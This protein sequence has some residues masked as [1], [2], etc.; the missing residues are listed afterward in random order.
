MVLGS[1]KPVERL[2][3]G[4]LLRRL[5]SGDASAFVEAY[6]IFAPKI[7][8]HALY[9]TSSHETAEDIMSLTFLRAWEYVSTNASEIERLKAFLYRIANNLIVDHYRSK[10][11]APVGLTEE[12]ERTMAV[13]ASA[14]SRAERALEKDRLHGA[15]GELREETRELLVMRYIDEL[16][17][18]EI[19]ALK[20]K[21]KNAVYVALHRAVKELKNACSGTLPE[22]SSA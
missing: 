18:E 16:S 3:E 15:L 13:E 5:R 2:K 21:K 7:Y 1:K 6:D 4:K 14:E 11:R 19:A 17:I 9:R 22:N 12:M 10:A 8:R 20:G